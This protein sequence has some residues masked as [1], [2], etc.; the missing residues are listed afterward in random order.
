MYDHT[1]DSQLFSHKL[2]SPY[3]LH[4]KQQPFEGWSKSFSFLK[5]RRFQRKEGPN[6]Q[7]TTVNVNYH[8]GEY[9]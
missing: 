3:P 8:F 2:L 1:Q 4:L 9:F 6:K 5:P 7:Q